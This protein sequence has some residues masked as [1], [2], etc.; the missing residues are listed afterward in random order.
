MHRHQ[1]V[2]T[3]PMKH[4][5]VHGFSVW[6]LSLNLLFVGA[7][8]VMAPRVVPTYMAYLTGKDLITHAADEY[9]PRSES[10]ADLKVRLAKLLNTNQIYDSSTDDIEVY[11]KGDA[12]VIDANC[13]KRFPLF[14]IVDGV[15]KFENLIVKTTPTGRT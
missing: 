1:F 12:I 9:D 2:A 3:R 6:P 5:G 7:L 10:I 13:D 4:A 14:W 8:L 11:G 15:L